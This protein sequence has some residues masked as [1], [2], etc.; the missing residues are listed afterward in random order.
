MVGGES[1][2]RYGIPNMVKLAVY[3]KSKNKEAINPNNP[4][5]EAAAK[6]IKRNNVTV[7]A[8]F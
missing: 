4:S 5:A 6:T 8:K 2:V 7:P 3:V 1:G